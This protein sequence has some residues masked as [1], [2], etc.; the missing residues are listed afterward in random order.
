MIYSIYA[1]AYCSRAF[2]DKLPDKGAR[3]QSLYDRICAELKARYTVERAAELF[4][5]LNIVERGQQTLN[6]MEWLGGQ[7]GDQVIVAADTLDSDDDQPDGMDPLKIIAQSRETKLVKVQKPPKSLITEADLA[8]IRSMAEPQDASRT[9]T[10]QSSPNTSTNS[11]DLEPRALAIIKNE[12]LHQ[13]AAKDGRQ[14]F[15]PF[16]TTKSDVHNVDR[17]KARSAGKHWINTAATPPLIRN[18][19]ARLITLGESIAAERLQQARV[20]EQMVRQAVERLDARRK[21]IAD[22][23]KLLPAGSELLDPNSFF[24]SYRQREEHFNEAEDDD[25]LSEHSALDECE[26]DEA[27][28]VSVLIH[29]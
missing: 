26:D 22:N 24:Q 23:I 6:Q 2:I 13:A 9:D 27:D 19:A 16:R 14:R 20:R 28:G 10:S 5:E 17:E 3:I 18:D 12:E 8:D 15:L 29:S 4:S 25:S 21:I 11:A 1:D 7:R